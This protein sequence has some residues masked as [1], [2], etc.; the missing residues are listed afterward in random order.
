MS[1]SNPSPLALLLAGAAAGAGAAGAARAG[2]GAL[3]PA[4]LLVAPVLLEVAEFGR[5][6]AS[7]DC[8]GGCCDGES[9]F[10]TGSG[11]AVLE[12]CA[13]CD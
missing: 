7:V 6:C 13:D 2:A 9:E 1:M 4:P 11:G 12:N 5:C 8:D 3:G 10:T